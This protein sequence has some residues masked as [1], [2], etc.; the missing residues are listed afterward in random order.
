M[1][2]PR[3]AQHVYCRGEVAVAGNGK[4]ANNSL[5]NLQIKTSINVAISGRCGRLVAA[6][7]VCENGEWWMDVSDFKTLPK[8]GILFS[9]HAVEW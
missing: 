8:K 1:A 7:D 5:N 3:S 6:N 4:Q 9:I 2:E